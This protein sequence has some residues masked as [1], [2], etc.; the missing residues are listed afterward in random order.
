M[1]RRFDKMRDDLPAQFAAQLATAT[2]RAEV[3]ERQ[4]Q[5][6]S[7]ALKALS[8]GKASNKASTAEAEQLADLTA[9]V[10]QLVNSASAAGT[11]KQLEPKAAKQCNDSAI[12]SL[13]ATTANNAAL[14]ASNAAFAAANA[15]AL[16]ASQN[17]KKN[18]HTKSS[19]DVAKTVV[20]P[21]R[22]ST[23][24]HP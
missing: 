12:K 13:H 14:A 22:S 2:T 11:M 20:K 15:A 1:Q 16:A 21:A 3:A 24:A 9:L 17:N 4:V 8:T 23:A 19:N 7:Q 18:A 10:G 5:E 6:L